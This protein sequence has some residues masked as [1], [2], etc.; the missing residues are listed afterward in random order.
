MVV[1]EAMAMGVPVLGGQASGAVPWLL[2]DGAGVLVDVR[3][4]RDIAGSI[5]RL[6][7]DAPLAES[8]ARQGFRRAREQFSGDSVAASYI[9]RLAALG[10]DS[11]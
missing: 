5:V 10:V 7:A 3:R 2:A 11:G 8:T 9:N 1:L 4:P 6:L